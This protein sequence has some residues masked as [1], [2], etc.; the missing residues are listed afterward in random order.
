MSTPPSTP[1]PEPQPAELQAPSPTAA[2]PAATPVLPTPGEVISSTLTGCT[3]TIG[4]PIGHG[5]FG[6]V[7]ECVDDWNNKLAAK[8]LKPTKPHDEV[9]A[10]ARAE[11]T[12]LFEVRHPQ[13]TYFFD[14]FEYRDAFYIITERC[15]LSLA[16]LL[17]FGWFSGPLWTLAVARSLLQ[18]VQFL[19][20][21]GYAHQDIHAANVF[22]L[23]ALNELNPNDTSAVQFR[24]GD[25]GVAKLIT[26]I[27]P[28][29]TR[30]QWM[31]P[32]EVLNPAEFGPPDHRVDIYH[33][34]LL[35]LQLEH[36]KELQFTRDEILDGKP[37]QMALE[38]R[39][40]FNFALEKALRRHVSKRTET[41]RELWRD[42]NSPA[43]ADQPATVQPQEPMT[44]E[45]APAPAPGAQ[46]GAEHL[47]ATEPEQIHPPLRAGSNAD[48]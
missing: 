39:A 9:E 43:Q 28:E 7:Y 47:E 13:I 6:I 10:A 48:K 18:A 46:P 2:P 32:P 21:S 42:L 38:L 45:T 37:R 1:H 23:W 31:L 29:N 8:V 14:T 30:A 40:P 22:T 19:H 34:G 36:S 33:C 17:G 25:L 27:H 16:Q 24:L 3:Y 35:L 4:E 15:E 11:I 41:A 44:I 5:S 26:E 20:L 12:K